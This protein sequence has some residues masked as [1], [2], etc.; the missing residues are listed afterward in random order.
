MVCDLPK[1]EAAGELTGTYE[2]LQA[3]VFGSPT[4]LQKCCAFINAMLAFD[5]PRVPEILN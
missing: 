1:G 3:A 5:I 2:M 4:G